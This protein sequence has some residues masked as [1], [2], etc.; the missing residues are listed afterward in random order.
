MKL[1]KLLTFLLM[2]MGIVQVE[3]WYMM[4]G[5]SVFAGLCLWEDAH[6]NRQCHL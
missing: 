5:L 3:F 2:A 4:L 1:L 6:P